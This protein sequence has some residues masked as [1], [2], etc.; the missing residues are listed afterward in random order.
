MT[1]MKYATQ[2]KFT[3]GGVTVV[4]FSKLQEGAFGVTMSWKEGRAEI[5]NLELA[6]VI[7]KDRFGWLRRRFNGLTPV[8]ATDIIVD[9]ESVIKTEGG[10]E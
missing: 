1:T 7:V 6:S 4:D 2:S 8:Y 10:Q 5:H 3:Q 9:G